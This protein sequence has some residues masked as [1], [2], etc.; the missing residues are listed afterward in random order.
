MIVTVSFAT[1]TLSISF[2]HIL[3]EG[4]NSSFLLKEFDCI[5]LLKE[6]H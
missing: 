4:S 6:M 5:E 2:P 1:M 3:R